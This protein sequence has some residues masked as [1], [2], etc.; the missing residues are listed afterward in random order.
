VQFTVSTSQDNK[1]KTTVEND[2]SDPTLEQIIT[3]CNSIIATN[4]LHSMINFTATKYL[5][6]YHR[7]QPMKYIKGTLHSK[8]TLDFFPLA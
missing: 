3:F 2:N 7:Q 5:Y 4:F 6:H 1:N 8:L